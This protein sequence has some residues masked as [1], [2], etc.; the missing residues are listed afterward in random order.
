MPRATGSY[1]AE[2]FCPSR[3]R[4]VTVRFTTDGEVIS[5]TA[6]AGGQTVTCGAPCTGGEHRL[7]M[8]AER[9]VELVA[10]SGLEV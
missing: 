3:R 2:M 5:C 8:D 10:G 7:L 4:R 6:F 9:P 1:T